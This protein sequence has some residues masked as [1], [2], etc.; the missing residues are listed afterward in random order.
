MITVTPSSRYRRVNPK[1]IAGTPLAG[2]TESVF[3][4][5]LGNEKAFKVK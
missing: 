3:K 2:V 1:N 5:S 4:P